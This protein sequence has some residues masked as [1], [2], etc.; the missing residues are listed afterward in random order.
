MTSR[1]DG[2][3]V[4]ALGWIFCYIYSTKKEIQEDAARCILP[5][6]FFYLLRAY[7]R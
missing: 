7:A 5:I 2:T 4:I 3:C 6:F 1:S